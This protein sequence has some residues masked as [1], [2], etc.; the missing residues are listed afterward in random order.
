MESSFVELTGIGASYLGE[1]FISEDD[2]QPDEA[3]IKTDYSLISAGTELSR[4]Y[5]LKQGFSYPVRPGY[6][7]VG[8][9]IARGSDITAGIGDAVFVNGPHASYLRWEH[10]DQVQ[11]PL[12]LKLPVG[13]DLQKATFINLILV[14]L[15]GVQLS[16]VQAGYRVGIFGLGNIGIITAAIYKKMGCKVFG[17]DPVSYRCQLAQEFGVDV[18][19]SEDDQYNALMKLNDNEGLD[20]AVD[21]TGL[22]PVIIS[23]VKCARPYGQVV[24]LGSPRQ[25]Y[26][27]DV[28]PLLSMIHMKDL[29]VFG[30]F[31][32][33]VP[34][35][36]QNGSDHSLMNNFRIACELIQEGLPL[37]KLISQVIDP[38]NCQQ[39]Y[40]DLM[41]D[42]ENNSAIIFDW[43]RY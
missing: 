41:Y 8:K 5:G 2:L 26:E 42:K 23:A 1:E 19:I 22:S 24:L 20:I 21:A 12:I 16:A 3:L 29:K 33:T 35:Y 11:G 4:A 31:N 6:S 38:I 27:C 9:I 18:V 34:L 25:A 30:A 32:K 10:G 7:A 14:A 39:A 36:P 40:H 28:T 17:F 43:R 15:Q 37:E 13:I